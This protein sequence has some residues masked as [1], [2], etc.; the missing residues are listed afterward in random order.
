MKRQLC[1]KTARPGG[2]LKAAGF[3]L[4]AAA[5]V[6][7]ACETAP[8]APM[9]TVGHVEGFAGDVAG[10]EPQAV[11]VA[12][13]VLSAGGSAADA[14]VALDFTLAVTLP[15]R[16]SLGSGGICL[17]YDNASQKVDALNFVPKASSDGAG[18]SAAP[19][20]IPGNARAMFALQSKY[21]RL[22]WEQLLAP[23]EKLA[24]NG[25]KVSKPLARDLSLAAG[26]L[27]KDPEA[28]RVFGRKEGGPMREGDTILQAD[29][30]VLIGRLR[31]AG[32]GDLYEGMLAPAVARR[33]SEAGDSTGSSI[34]AGDLRD[35]Q[36]EWGEPV[37][38]AHG[39]DT[40]NFAP[41]PAA[42]GVVAG[43]IWLMLAGDDAYKKAK[44]VER[45]HLFAEASLRAYADRAS[46]F[47]SDG[48]A[49][50]AP[51]D[52]LTDAHA[53]ELMSSYSADAHTP[54]GSLNP[55]PVPMPENPAATSFVVM[56]SSGSAVACS[57]T[58]N[59]LFGLGK[60]ARGTGIIVAAAPVRGTGITALSP[61]IVVD[62]KENQLKFAAA[63][64]G[65]A[66]AP[67]ALA[68]VA[69]ETLVKGRTLAKAMAVKRVLDTGAPD[70]LVYE[71]G[72]SA[73]TVTALTAQKYKL[74]EIESLGLVNAV[75]CPDG[76]P[77]ETK[78]CK[79]AADPRGPGGTF[80]SES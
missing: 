34:S 62:R 65:G 6:L 56:D 40:L 78:S 19:V 75:S 52:V 29:L 30:G 67:A 18:Q 21:G 61:M 7:V 57:L 39:D 8:K 44:D 20:A 47:G 63:A 23:A 13:Q 41:P 64:S 45:E 22:L 50:T 71:K 36:P 51:K 68:T 74:F 72:L 32:P 35:Y 42:A 25:T 80:A 58:M 26:L 12:R 66:A 11:E 37:A 79:A 70:V 15:S 14:A 33:F 27:A 16:A 46:W 31:S 48:N 77:E 54:A 17:V 9:G 28:M 60:M 4:A 73:D 2:G 49:K 1:R 76:A 38:V 53:K 43:E 5:C 69:L 55:A 24:Q 59:N 3:A 10:D